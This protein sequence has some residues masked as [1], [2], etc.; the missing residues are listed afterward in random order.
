MSDSTLLDAEARLTEDHDGSYRA[1]LMGTL[2]KF[3]DEFAFSRQALLPPDEHEIVEKMEC[4]LESALA[5]VRD[6]EPVKDEH[7]QQVQTV[8]NP[9]LNL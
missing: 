8:F 4:A 6:Y 5:I 3:R 7:P 2:K 9:E 1:A